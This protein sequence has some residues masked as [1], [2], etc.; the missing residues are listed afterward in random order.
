MR[1]LLLLLLLPFCASSSFDLDQQIEQK[2]QKEQNQAGL[3]EPALALPELE[4]NEDEGEDRTSTLHGTPPGVSL[5][6][7]CGLRTFAYDFG[8]RLLGSTA[9]LASARLVAEGNV[10][11]ALQLSRCPKAPRRPPIPLEDDG[12]KP[13]SSTSTQLF[14]RLNRNTLLHFHLFNSICS[15]KLKQSLIASIQI[16]FAFSFLS[17]I[18]N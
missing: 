4:E 1:S 2:E 6:A 5:A 14:G 9:T 8:K 18:P 13:F 12:G 16:R 11:D 10:H 3:V 17:L 15:S 7:D